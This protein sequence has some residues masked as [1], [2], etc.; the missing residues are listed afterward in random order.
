MSVLQLQVINVIKANTKKYKK[1][2]LLG[3]DEPMEHQ[4]Q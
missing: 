4:K 1:T 3:D 2:D